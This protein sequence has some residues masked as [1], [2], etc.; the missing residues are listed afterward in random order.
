MDRSRLLLMYYNLGYLEV[1]RGWT[2]IACMDRK[3]RSWKQLPRHDR[4]EE[5]K[6]AVAIRRRSIEDSFPNSLGSTDIE[7]TTAT[8]EDLLLALADEQEEAGEQDTPYMVESTDEETN[9]I[10]D[11]SALSASLLGQ[12]D[13]DQGLEGQTHGL[14]HLYP[15]PLFDSHRV[16]GLGSVNDDGAAPP[17]RIRSQSHEESSLWFPWPNKIVSLEVPHSGDVLISC[18]EQ[19]CTLDVLM[20]LPRSAFSHRQL[21]VLLWLLRVNNITLDIPSLKSMKNLQTKLHS[22]HGIRTLRYDGAF[23]NKYY[24]NSI[25]DIISQVNPTRH[26]LM[27]N[28][29]NL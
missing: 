4:S 22:L 9:E 12:L 11:I 10:L 7:T 23:G 28:Y 13:N 1:K 19:S 25:A 26:Q 27:I 8:L 5:H 20:H 3:I 24:V 6:H 21:N 18:H 15:S 16:L 17:K 14:A 2:C 29:L